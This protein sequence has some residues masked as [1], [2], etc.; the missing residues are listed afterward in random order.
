MAYTVKQLQSAI[1]KTPWPGPGLCL[2]WVTDVFENLGMDVT[3]YATAKQAKAAWCPYSISD[4]KPGMV[5]GW[6]GPTGSHAG[7]IVIYIDDEHVYSSER[8]STIVVRSLSATLSWY[9]SYGTPTCGWC[10]GAKIKDANARGS[11]LFDQFIW[12]G[13]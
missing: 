3:H 1:D 12:V 13:Y 6:N 5:I 8:V 10:M 9:A 11:T 4:L 2:G 7:H